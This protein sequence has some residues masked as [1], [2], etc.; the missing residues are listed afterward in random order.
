VKFVDFDFALGAD[1]TK[2]LRAKAGVDPRFA[3]LQLLSKE[4]KS[5]GYA[6]HMGELRKESFW[7]PSSQAQTLIVER[8]N[9][10]LEQIEVGQSTLTQQAFHLENLRRSILHQAFTGQL[11]KEN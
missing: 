4:I 2:V 1:G 10:L 5:K 11:T 3:Y 6:R 9:K 8:V 7:L